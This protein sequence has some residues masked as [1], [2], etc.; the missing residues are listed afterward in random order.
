LVK[1]PS[2]GACPPTC[3]VWGLELNNAK[4]LS[5]TLS[6]FL[7]INISAQQNKVNKV[8]DDIRLQLTSDKKK[9]VNEEILFTPGNE[10]FVLTGIKPWYND[11]LKDIRY[12][13]LTITARM[14]LK[15]QE[16]AYRQEAV[17]LVVQ[18]GND[19]DVALAG[20]AINYLTHFN[21]RDF[22]KEACDS[23]VAQLKKQTPHFDI[24]VRLAGFL[25]LKEQIPFLQNKLSGGK[26]STKI[27]WNI[28]LA[29]A[30]MGSESN[31]KSILDLTKGYPVD[32][33]IMYNILPDLV[34][35]RQKPVFNFLL[36][37]LYSDKKNCTSA[38][39]NFSGHILC[40]YRVMEALAAVV[41][42]FPIKTRLSGS[43]IT[44]D[45][46]KALQTTR[47]WFKEHKDYELKK[48]IY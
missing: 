38:N 32:D 41:K 37:I 18:A 10:Q 2:Q 9:Q 19:K 35:T 42:D 27:Q 30:R 20:S 6:L 39:P 7:T 15:S 29:L 3:G 44:Q 13:A 21:R 47:D 28:N 16:P 5:L 34:Y 4:T 31:T 48:D 11:T 40:G 26:N 24:L 8:L 36:E 43:L 45:Y 46:D 14:G 1:A 17:R 12:R 23:L 25:D 22:T 33:N